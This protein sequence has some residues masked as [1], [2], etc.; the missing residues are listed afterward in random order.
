[1]IDVLEN[2]VSSVF[3]FFSLVYIF[4]KSTFPI[5]VSKLW[6]YYDKEFSDAFT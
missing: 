2:S 6:I 1:M 5:T 4:Y 3:F